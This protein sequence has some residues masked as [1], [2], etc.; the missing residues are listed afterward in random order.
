[1][2]RAPDRAGQFA[3]L[4]QQLVGVGDHVAEGAQVVFSQHAFHGGEHAG[5]FAA[6]SDDFFVRQDAGIF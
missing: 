5:D 1:M 4:L 3:V 6:S 2:K